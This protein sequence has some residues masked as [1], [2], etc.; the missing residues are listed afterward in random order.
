MNLSWYFNKVV[1]F[2]NKSEP[3]IQY[4]WLKAGYDEL[5]S[6]EPPG[7]DWYP[8]WSERSGNNV[9]IWVTQCASLY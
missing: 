7:E 4:F 5:P 9:V 6:I 2:F 8:I 1:K 3:K